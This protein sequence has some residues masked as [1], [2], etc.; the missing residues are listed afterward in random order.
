MASAAWDAQP[1]RSDWMIFFQRLK[2]KHLSK[3]FFFFFIQ[4]FQVDR[5]SLPRLL[6]ILSLRIVTDNIIIHFDGDT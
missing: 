3:H 6:A 4:L 5:E 1:L 2:S